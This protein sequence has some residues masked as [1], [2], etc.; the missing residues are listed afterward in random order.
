MDKKYL[1]IISVLLVFLGVLVIFLSLA[2]PGSRQVLSV[3]MASEPV[4]VVET[5]VGNDILLTFDSN[6][7]TGYEWQVTQTQ[8]SSVQTQ[9]KL[10]RADFLQK[11]IQGESAQPRSGGILQIASTDY[12]HGETDRLGVAGKE[13]WVFK[14]LK[15]GR[16]V[17]S[18]SYV[19]PWEKDIAPASKKIFV[20]VINDKVS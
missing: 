13:L 5:Q 12:I 19:R 1:V 18:F 2:S 17:L 9:R 16:T 10:R 6:I 4:T 7:T 20:V 8:F 3:G 11:E 15:P 14:A